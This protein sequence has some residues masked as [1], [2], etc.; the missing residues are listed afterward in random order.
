[1]HYN[2]IKVGMP[3]LAAAPVILQVRAADPLSR[4]AEQPKPPPAP[5]EDVP[6]GLPAPPRLPDT[7]YIFYRRFVVVACLKPP[8]GPRPTRRSGRDCG[9][10]RRGA[11]SSRRRWPSR[12]C[13][14]AGE[15]G[16]WDGG[17]APVL[18]QADPKRRIDSALGARLRVHPCS[19]ELG[20]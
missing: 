7:H 4:E 11:T 10:Q 6:D 14:P 3:Q 18:R 8:D 13:R 5:A 2:I 16:S 17:E 9:C 12:S 20:S 15:S 1:M 19:A